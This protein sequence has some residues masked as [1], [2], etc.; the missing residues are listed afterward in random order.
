MG[1]SV[2]KY[3]SALRGIGLASERAYHAHG[4]RILQTFGTADGEYELAYMRTLLA[5]KRQG[6][7][8]GLIDLEQ[9]EIGFFVLAD[10]ARFQN[11]P[12]PDRHLA[13]RVAHR[14]RQGDTDALR[15]LYYVSVGHD[16]SVRI[17]DHPRADRVLAHDERGLGPFFLLQWP[18][19]RDQNLHY[20]GRNLRSQ[21]LQRAIELDQNAW[22]LI[23]FRLRGSWANVILG[24]LL[25]GLLAGLGLSAPGCGPA[26][27]EEENRNA[28]CF[29][30][31][32]FKQI[33][34]R[35]TLRS[36]EKC[37][38]RT[39]SWV[40]GLDVEVLQ[41]RRKWRPGRRLSRGNLVATVNEWV[42]RLLRE[43]LS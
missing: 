30:S 20:C 28:S 40:I 1:A 25:H 22:G 7:Q 17:Y 36:R 21:G 8:I 9:C 41:R 35:N 10:E 24:R 11:A 39:L 23:R 33:R 29:S 3:V 6:W 13:R 2:C 32:D 5:E 19:S 43:C 4:D 16:V 18:V 42:I 37:V 26:N 15:A 31:S 27:R 34:H 12:L 38:N 14:Q